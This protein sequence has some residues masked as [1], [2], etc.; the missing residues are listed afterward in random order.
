MTPA[1][2]S[3]DTMPNKYRDRL[4]KYAIRMFYDKGF[5][6]QPA[7][8]RRAS[9]TQEGRV[10]RHEGGKGVAREWLLIVTRVASTYQYRDQE[11]SWREFSSL[12]YSPLER[13][14]NDPTRI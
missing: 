11:P 3:T 8:R 14:F 7:R 1:T 10:P 13:G 5:A 2:T 9:E 6:K 4:V 12:Y